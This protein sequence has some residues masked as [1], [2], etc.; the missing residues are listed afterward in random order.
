MAPRAPG[1]IK[2]KRGNEEI[3]TPD[4]ELAP[5]A[6]PGI[7][8]VIVDIW[9]GVVSLNTLMQRETTGSNKGMATQA[10]VDL[11]TATINAATPNYNF[12]RVVIIS[13][14]EHDKGYTMEDPD[15]V[16]FVLPNQGRIN[17]T[18]ANLLNTAKLLMACTPNGI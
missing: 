4:F 14:E 3:T 5:D 7:A 6:V 16:V 13:E 10:A 18:G 9:T 2:R 11:A 8:Q 17:S 1:G 15:D 12:V